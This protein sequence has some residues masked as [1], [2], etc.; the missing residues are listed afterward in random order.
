MV[1]LTPAL[2]NLQELATLHVEAKSRGDKATEDRLLEVMREFHEV[3]Y[4]RIISETPV[5]EQM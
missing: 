1:R 5:L 3:N 2:D 4:E